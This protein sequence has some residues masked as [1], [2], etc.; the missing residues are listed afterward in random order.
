VIA[1]SLE[2]FE[3]AEGG[4]FLPEENEQDLLDFINSLNNEINDLQT[5]LKEEREKSDE[6]ISAKNKR[7]ENLESQLQ[8]AEKLK[9]EL[10]NIIEN[11]EKIIKLKDQQINI[12]EQK[13]ELYKEQ[14]S[15]NKQI[16]EQKNKIISGKDELIEIEQEKSFKGKINC[17]IYGLVTGLII[18]LYAN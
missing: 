18:G 4:Y 15:I 14:S 17:G 16:L 12:L 1:N 7:I 6:V 2:Y 3:K 9:K 10:Q 13:I 8:A 5:A 11:N